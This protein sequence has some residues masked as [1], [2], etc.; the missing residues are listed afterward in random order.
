MNKNVLQIHIRIRR[1]IHL[2]VVLFAGL[3]TS[4]AFAEDWGVYALVPASAPAM[5]LEAVG[6]GTNEG[7]VVS[8]GKPAGTANQKWV[9]TPKGTNSY[10]IK[11][12]YGSTLV[13]AVAKGG[14]ANG[15]AVVLETDQ[16]QPWQVWG[17]TKNENGTYSLIPTH[18]PDKGLDD[19]G[20]KQSPGAKQDLWTYHP[21]DQHL[22]W[23]IKPLAGTA[24]PAADTAPA[25]YVAPSIK[26]EDILEG[27]IKKCSFTNSMIF[28]G[29]VRE[30]TVFIPAQ[31]DG[32]TSACVYV[33]TDG[34]NPKEKALLET[35][36]AS[37]EMPVTIGVFVR[38]GEL[39]APMKNTLGRRNRCFEY[40]GIGGQQCPL[41]C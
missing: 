4:C 17:I 13:L 12:S 10:S 16:G 14:A 34:Y 9:I 20:G 11:P 5:V 35:L 28:P 18:A 15:T 41:L 40:D 36:I 39:P 2:T 7:T 19:F 29:T 26:P 22:Q 33:R 21:S 25:A 31:Y 37:K 24:V 38:P 27:A 30:V 23:L 1:S 32:A 6:S 8:V 3:A